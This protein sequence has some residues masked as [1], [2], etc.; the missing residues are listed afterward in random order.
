RCIVLGPAS[1]VWISDTSDR[2]ARGQV[3][4]ESTVSLDQFFLGKSW[5]CSY[6]NLLND[7]TLIISL[8]HVFSMFSATLNL[9]CILSKKQEDIRVPKK[10]QE[11]IHTEA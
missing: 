4:I 8:M 5:I 1:W 11:D 2:S 6:V 10:K 3:S 7:L 9:T